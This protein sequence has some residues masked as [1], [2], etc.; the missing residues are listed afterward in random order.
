MLYIFKKKLTYNLLLLK[1]QFFG[2]VF[3][4]LEALALVTVVVSAW[5]ILANINL[6]SL[7]QQW[8]WI[9]R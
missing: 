4:T 9:V 6:D 8:F 2:S 7:F 3:R 1:V 5:F